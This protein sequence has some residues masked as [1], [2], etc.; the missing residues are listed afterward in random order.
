MNSYLLDTDICIYSM[1]GLYDLKEKILHVGIENCFISE[2]TVLELT[3][4]VENSDASKKEK[5]LEKLN[6]FL[7]SIDT[8]SVTSCIKIFAKEKSRLKKSGILIDHFDL[9]IGTT[10]VANNMIL[11]TNNSKHFDRI[12]SIQ[13]ENWSQ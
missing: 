10:A 11:V 5:N 8:I 7:N 2:I 3:Y 1:K 9:I 4:G 12:E 6:S 13:I